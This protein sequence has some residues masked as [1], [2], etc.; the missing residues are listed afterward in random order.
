MIFDGRAYAKEIEEKVK[1]RVEK[2][3]PKP[4]IVSVLVGD[5]PASVLYTKLKREAAE[6]VGI[7]FEILK[8][9]DRKL[10]IVE[11]KRIIAELGNRYDVTGVMV[12]LPLP[13]VSRKD[14]DEILEAIPLAKDID[15]LRY[16]ESNVMPATVRAVIEILDNIESSMIDNLRSKNYVVV[17]ARG[18][19]GTP[20]VYYL[21]KRGIKAVELEWDTQRDKVEELLRHGEVIVSCVGKEG[22]ITPDMINDGAIVIDVGAPSGDMTKEVYQKASIAVGV[23]NGVG[24][25]TIASLLVN[26]EDLYD[27]K[28]T[29]K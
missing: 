6:R 26:T 4:K 28:F 10:S 15:G 18:S 8:I 16:R 23:P 27:R 5:D 20:L 24:P 1:N 13:G 17:G 14:V 12:Q 11:L 29:Q 19:V 9:V 2:L 21:Q 3:E 7:Q 25:V 22:L